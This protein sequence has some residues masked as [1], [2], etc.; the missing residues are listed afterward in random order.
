M[1]FT[2]LEEFWKLHAFTQEGQVG[3]DDDKRDEIAKFKSAPGIF[4]FLRR[5]S[6]ALQKINSDLKGPQ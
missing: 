3:K 1:F 6:E 4:S 5:T 2:R